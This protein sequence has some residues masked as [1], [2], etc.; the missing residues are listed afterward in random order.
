M[1]KKSK[2]DDK[3]QT[4]VMKLEVNAF[5]ANSHLPSHTHTYKHSLE[6]THTHIQTH[7]RTYTLNN[8]FIDRR[9]RS[10]SENKENIGE[11]TNKIRGESCQETRNEEERKRN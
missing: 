3:K 2:T 7:T 11:N 5:F 9:L 8:K 10:N 1:K 6:P 4:N